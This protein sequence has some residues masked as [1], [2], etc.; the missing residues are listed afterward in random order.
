M[1]IKHGMITP[2]PPVVKGIDIQKGIMLMME[3]FIFI[4]LNY[5]D[6]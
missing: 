4:I 5:L 6:N 1:N 2:L 3:R